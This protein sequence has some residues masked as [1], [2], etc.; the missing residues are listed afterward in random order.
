MDKGLGVVAMDDQPAQRGPVRVGDVPVPETSM[1]HPYVDE[2]RLVAAQ[3]I[4]DIAALPD[5]EGGNVAPRRARLS[6]ATSM[7]EGMRFDGARGSVFAANLSARRGGVAQVWRF[8]AA[9]ERF[10]PGRS[11]DV[12]IAV[13]GFSAERSAQAISVLACGIRKLAAKRDAA[14]RIGL[15]LARPLPGQVWAKAGPKTLIVDQGIA[16][17][18]GWHVARCSEC[19]RPAYGLGRP[20]WK[21]DSKCPRH[22]DYGGAATENRVLRTLAN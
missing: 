19:F 20:D 6:T 5:Q 14:P 4:R 13:C 15:W 1:A 10:S 12:W 7:L 11:N 22:Y 3:E 21:G 16:L 17:R 9:E 8:D 2:V 18:M